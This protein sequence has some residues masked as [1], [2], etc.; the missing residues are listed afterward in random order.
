MEKTKH[1]KLV[2]TL[3]TDSESLEKLE[4]TLEEVLFQF[5]G[6]NYAIRKTNLTSEQLYEKIPLDS[7]LYRKLETQA[8]EKGFPNV[9]DYV[10]DMLE[11]IFAT[12]KGN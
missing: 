1:V 8:K 9:D 6:D 4:T 11:N 5:C 12:L 7:K 3:S 10:I 2:I